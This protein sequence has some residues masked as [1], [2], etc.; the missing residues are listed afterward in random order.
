VFGT[1]D[2]LRRPKAIMVEINPAQLALALMTMV[3]LSALLAMFA[4][5][6]WMFWRLAT[7]QTLL[8]SQPLVSLSPPTW[9]G[10]TVFLAFSTYVVMNVVVAGLYAR[11]AGRLPRK[12]ATELKSPVEPV[13][14]PEAAKTPRG[15]KP[16]DT[17]SNPIGQPKDAAGK[18]EVGPPSEATDGENPSKPKESDDDD[19]GKFSLIEQMFMVSVI[20]CFLLVVLPVLIRVTSGTRLR[21]LGLSFKGWER[22]AALGAMATL[23]AAPAVYSVQ[24]AA[25]LYWRANAHPL[26][27]M[28]RKEFDSLGVA[29]LAVISAVIL[30]P[31]V[32]ELM[33]RGLFQRW[34]I[35][36]LAR[37][38]G[39]RRP[40]PLAPDASFAAADD[41]AVSS[42][43]EVWP[44]FTEGAMATAPEVRSP[45]RAG[46]IA[47]V[48]ATSLF[49]AVVHAPQWP[50]PIPL[51]VL[52]LIIG[53][54]YHRTGSLIAAIFM[55]A[56]FNGFSTLAMFVGIL[57]GQE[58]EVGKAINGNWT[59]PAVVV[60]VERGICAAV[61]DH[62]VLQNWNSNG[63]LL[64]ERISDC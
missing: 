50:A 22:Q 26:E 52:A 44:E 16:A 17:K 55:H 43:Q 61:P 20:N 60:P 54:V 47:A 57:G 18:I 21:D 8:P 40:L 38:A 7:G 64:D 35:D 59:L 51:F 41:G 48:T 27:K 6:A 29:D 14:Q 45:T 4:G 1:V 36:F 2:L 25:L 31:I 49:F 63:F 56:T 32:E 62:P 9:R 23:I 30:A 19:A 15:S 13:K 12:P 28:L 53:Y 39:P 46:V 5:W 42:E 3:M 58:K 33:F 34:C 11:T 10:G 37:R 24:F